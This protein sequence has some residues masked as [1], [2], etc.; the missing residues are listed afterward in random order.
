MD[1]DFRYGILHSGHTISRDPEFSRVGRTLDGGR[2]LRGHSSGSAEFIDGGHSS[3]SAEFINGSDSLGSNSPD[4]TWVSTA[5]TPSAA[6]WPCEEKPVGVGNMAFFIDLDASG[7]LMEGNADSAV[8][9]FVHSSLLANRVKRGSPIMKFWMLDG[10]SCK[11]MKAFKFGDVPGGVGT[12]PHSD[13]LL[14]LLQEDDGPEFTED[15]TSGVRSQSDGLGE[16]AIDLTESLQGNDGMEFT[17]DTTSGATPVWTGKIVRDDKYNPV[18]DL[19]CS[20]EVKEFRCTIRFFLP[21]NVSYWV[22]GDASAN[23]R[24]TVIWNK[25]VSDTSH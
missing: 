8:Q 7:D 24:V 13:D 25:A 6:M 19:S 10:G 20:I 1:E 3:G 11:V 5:T 9:I 18:G 2:N 15:T 12:G 14:K 22:G 23:G 21:L 17:G 4:M 16:D